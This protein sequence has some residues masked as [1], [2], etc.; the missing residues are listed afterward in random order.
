MEKDPKITF[1]DRVNWW[2]SQNSLNKSIWSPNSFCFYLIYFIFVLHTHNFSPNEKLWKWYIPPHRKPNIYIYSPL[3]L[4]N[5][6]NNNNIPS[7]NSPT[8]FHHST[9]RSSQSSLLNSP[10]TLYFVHGPFEPSKKNSKYRS[11]LLHSSQQQKQQQLKE[12]S[13][14]R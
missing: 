10:T 2:A 9:T 6:K 14:M 3:T 7:T 8:T 12:N 1:A 11:T 4:V 5:I 13:D